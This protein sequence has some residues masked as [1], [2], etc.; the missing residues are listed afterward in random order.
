[1]S[2]TSSLHYD[3]VVVDCHHDIIL[4][5]AHALATGRPNTFKDRWIAEL[6]AGGVD[7]QVM[8]IHVESEYQNEAALRRTLQLLELMHREAEKNPADLVI[9][10]NGS[11][12]DLGLAERKIVLVPA[13]ESCDA[14][15][16]DPDLITTFFRLGVRMASFTWFGRT[17]LADGSGEE[18]GSRLTRTG[19]AVLEEMERVGMLV[20][21]S[22]LSPAGTDHVLEISK[23][24]V[25]ASH[26][27]ARALLDHHR[28][29]SDEHLEAIARTGGVIG[30]NFFP[31]F[32]DPG[33]PTLDRIVDHIEHIA[34][35]AGVDHV[36]LG[37]DLVKDYVDE[38]YPESLYPELRIE[39]LDAR[40]T[41]EGLAYSKDF[42]ALTKTL[43]KR[44]FSKEDIQKVLGENFL[45]LF[46][47]EMGKPR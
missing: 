11:E 16:H 9:A 35:V 13:L 22:H 10:G 19:V 29:L 42:P 5:V 24:P 18:T 43:E 40:A 20:D 30:V 23:R 8:P 26:S 6:R 45:N 32:I 4:L 17:G 36:G 27:S 47:A 44:G 3:P 25:V 33:N 28:N 14:I 37:P 1:M 46:R 21:V 15:G 12:I 7:V 39:G 31:G 2:V 41:I 38:L 34:G